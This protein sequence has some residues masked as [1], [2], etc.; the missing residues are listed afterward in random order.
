MISI[1]IP[2]Y[3]TEK[4][5]HRCLDSILDSACEDFEVILV[6]D[7]STD[8]SPR[9]CEEYAAKD[10]RI[11][12]IHQKNQGVS[13]ARNRGIC[14][15]SGEWIIF[16]DSDDHISPEFPGMVAQE[17]YKDT[18]L[19]LFDFVKSTEDR[20]PLPHS[21]KPLVFGAGRMPE[22]LKRI[23]VPRR[24]SSTGNVDFRS[25]CAR[26]YKKSIIDQYSIRFSPDIVIGEDL[27][28]NMEYQLRARSC[29]YIPTPVYTYDIHTGSATHGFRPD[30]IKN[31]EK[32]QARL[33]KLLIKCHMFSS[34]ET[35]FYSYSLENM[36]YVLI[37]GIFNPDNP[38]P[39]QTKYRQCAIMRR[40]HIYR[41]AMTY[42]LRTGILPRRIL[43][44]FFWLR[45]YPAADII[46]H[47][48]YLY[49]TAE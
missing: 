38:A 6:N 10:S 32:L 45:C 25:P 9:I 31:H 44:F 4:Y 40:N 22:L 39:R 17:K 5:L 24:L 43:V 8:R 37:H 15:C 16:I 13:S 34:L 28:F 11:K 23:L 47:I 33:K 36:T 7:G 35:E 19:L 21:A 46:S 26:A 20:K 2:V 41:K 48:S 14:E 30:L 29:V 18:D 49:L 1:I 27:L 42:N 3:N 12:V